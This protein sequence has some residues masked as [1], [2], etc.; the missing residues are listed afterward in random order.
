MSAAAPIITDRGEF[1]DALSALRKGHV[2]IRVYDRPG[3]CLLDGCPVYWSFR[4]L[5]DYGLIVEYD[6]PEGFEAVQYYRLTRRGRAFADK[7]CSS[8]RSRPW[9]QRLVLRVTG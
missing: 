8:W 2:L 5:L 3:G 6:N 9:I 4:T 7:A 1:V